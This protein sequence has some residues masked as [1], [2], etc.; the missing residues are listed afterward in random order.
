MKTLLEAK[1]IQL[2]L[3][4]S[5]LGMTVV[6]PQDLFLKPGGV[7]HD[8]L[9][10]ARNAS[11]LLVRLVGGGNGPGD[12][13]RQRRVAEHGEEMAQELRDGMCHGIIELGRGEK[14]CCGG[15]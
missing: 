14:E 13:I 8:N 9:S 12:E 11:S 10:N 3:E 1:V 7:V 4:A 2:A 5:V 6:L 15:D